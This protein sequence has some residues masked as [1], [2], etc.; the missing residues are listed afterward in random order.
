MVAN[1]AR[2]QVNREKS[3]KKSFF[4][5]PVRACEFGLARQARSSRVSPL[6]LHSQVNWIINHQSSIINHQSGA[7]P[8]HGAPPAFRDGVIVHIDCKV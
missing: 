4:P 6:I 5:V 2:G 3:K 8:T 1:L 7:M